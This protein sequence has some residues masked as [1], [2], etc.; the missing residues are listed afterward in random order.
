MGEFLHIVSTFPTV[1]F[2]FGLG[3]A[4]VYWLFTMIGA[5]DLDVLDGIAGDLDLDFDADVDVDADLDADGAGSAATGAWFWFADS[6]RLGRVPVAITLS[7]LLLWGWVTSFMVVWLA[8]QIGAPSTVASI[9][10][11]FV[12]AVGAVAITNLSS[13]PLE[14]MFRTVGARSQDSLIGEICEVTTGRV[15]SRFGQAELT[16]DADHLTIPVRCD[17]SEAL[18]RG[19]RALIVQF[20]PSREAFVVEPLVDPAAERVARRTSETDRT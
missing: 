3:I 13:R 19:G 9:A 5:L 1:L 16:V 18:A 20:D 6:M 17:T 4:T 11:L 15:D 12:S 2:T 10:A 7:F 8:N 14:P